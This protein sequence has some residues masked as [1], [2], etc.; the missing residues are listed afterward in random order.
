MSEI[1]VPL[2]LQERV[3]EVI[4]KDALCGCCL[5]VAVTVGLSMPLCKRCF[6]WLGLNRAEGIKTILGFRNQSMLLEYLENIKN[7]I[8][9]P[10]LNEV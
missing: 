1:S 2:K 7:G 5:D 9:S 8:E 6:E 3:I 4:I 10:L